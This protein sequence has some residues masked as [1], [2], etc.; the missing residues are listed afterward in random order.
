M[1][2]TYKRQDRKSIIFW[3]QNMYNKTNENKWMERDFA[4]IERIGRNELNEMGSAF[5]KAKRKPGL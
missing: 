2:K 4:V 1:K 3:K 5:K